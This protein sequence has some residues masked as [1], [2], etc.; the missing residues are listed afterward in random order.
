[1]I[2]V[3]S[4]YFTM[5]SALNTNPALSH[6]TA[7]PTSTALGPVSAVLDISSLLLKFAS[8]IEM[9]VKQSMAYASAAMVQF[10]IS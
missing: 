1:M 2:G 3:S 8:Y 6:K 10:I 4:F 9:L 5:F 7:P